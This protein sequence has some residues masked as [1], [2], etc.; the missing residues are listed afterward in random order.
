[1]QATQVT[2]LPILYEDEYLLA[3][4]KSAGVLSHPNRNKENRKCAFE[5]DYNLRTRCFVFGSAKTWL[6]HRLDSATSGVLLAAKNEQTAAA[7]QDLFKERQMKKGYQ[8]LVASMP[9]RKEGIWKDFIHTRERQQGIRSKIIEGRAPNAELRFRVAE[10][11]PEHGLAQLEIDLKTGRTHQIRVQAAQRKCPVV[12]DRT[13][14]NFQANRRLKKIL[15]S[16]R[17]FLHSR[18]LSFTHPV[19]GKE[20]SI[21]ASL[22]AELEEAL[23]RLRG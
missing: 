1:M 2:T 19:T 7:L 8:A 20:L 3:V 10:K 12:G 15:G 23:E 4:N 11:F 18:S 5:G 6:I 16:N 9:T 17:L 21:E 22:P 14:G 13:Y